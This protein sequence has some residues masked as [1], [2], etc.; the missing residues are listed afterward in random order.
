MDAITRASAT[1]DLHDFDFLTGRWNILNRRLKTPLAG[2]IEWDEFPA[3]SRCEQ[4]LG[5][6]ANIDE[7]EFATKGFSGLTI[8]VFDLER[9]RWAIYWVN[10]RVGLMLTPVYGG[11]EGDRGEFYG[12]DVDEGR[13]IQVRFL[14]QRQGADAARWEQ[15]F[16]LDG[17]EWETNWTMDLRRVE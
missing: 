15:A 3:T 7:I 13:T 17:R 9:R 11:F 10:S 1:G 5:S 16:L 2:S 4:R 8:R 14:W 12:E 6:V